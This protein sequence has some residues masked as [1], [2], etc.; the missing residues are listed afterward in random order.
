MGWARYGV[1]GRDRAKTETSARRAN[2]ACCA[3]WRDLRAKIRPSDV[4][5]PAATSRHRLKPGEIDL[6]RIWIQVRRVLMR[7]LRFRC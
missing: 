7:L 4:G 5:G 1:A 3:G 6:A 2:R